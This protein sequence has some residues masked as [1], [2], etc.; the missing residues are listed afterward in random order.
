MIMMT[1]LRYLAFEN[2]SNSLRSPGSVGNHFIRKVV[3][4]GCHLVHRFVTDRGAH[5]LDEGH[6]QATCKLPDCPIALIV[7]VDDDDAAVLS[8]LAR[9]SDG[10]RLILVKERRAQLLSSI[11]TRR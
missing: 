11:L 2:V 3:G 10:G 5:A 1:E 7:P 4:Q 8:F 9:Q 6:P